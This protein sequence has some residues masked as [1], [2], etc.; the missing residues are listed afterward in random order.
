MI[1]SGIIR[2]PPVWQGALRPSETDV[3]IMG[4]GPA[5]SSAALVLS[6]NGILN[7]L[8]TRERWTSDTPHA[9]I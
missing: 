3:L 2:E 8:V 5:G 9:H 4:S 6:T 1:E 7:V